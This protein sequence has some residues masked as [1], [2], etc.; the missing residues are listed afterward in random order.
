M[1]ACKQQD[2]HSGT[3]FHGNYPEQQKNLLPTVLISLAKFIPDDREGRVLTSLLAAESKT[4]V[5]K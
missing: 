1:F 4:K 2:Q 3:K 5:V